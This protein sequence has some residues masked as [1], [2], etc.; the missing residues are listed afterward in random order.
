M[1][2]FLAPAEPP[3]EILPA[4]R[5]ADLRAPRRPAEPAAPEALQRPAAMEAWGATLL[6]EET[7]TYLPMKLFRPAPAA[8]EEAPAAAVP[9]GEVERAEAAPAAGAEAAARAVPAGM[10]ARGEME[11]L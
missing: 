3:A 5:R 4:E 1:A 7:A 9:A 6:P 10:A 2:L 8:E 11:A